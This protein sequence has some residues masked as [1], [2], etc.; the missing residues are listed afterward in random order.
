MQHFDPAKVFQGE[1][2]WRLKVLV[3]SPIFRVEMN[4]LGV[5]LVPLVLV[6]AFQLSGRYFLLSLFSLCPPAPAILRLERTN[7]ETTKFLGEFSHGPMGPLQCNALISG[8]L[9]ACIIEHPR[10]QSSIV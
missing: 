10:N 8:F 4:D 1:K 5:P 7:L 3:Q 9:A 6:A 2:A